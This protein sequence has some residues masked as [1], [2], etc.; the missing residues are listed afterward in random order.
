LEV[1]V[2][3]T[4]DICSGNK[5]R[6]LNQRHP[7]VLTVQAGRAERYKGLVVCGSRAKCVKRL[8]QS[9]VGR[10]RISAEEE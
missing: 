5:S 9:S 6:S 7:V 1:T 2:V 10:N 3:I 8:C 4:P